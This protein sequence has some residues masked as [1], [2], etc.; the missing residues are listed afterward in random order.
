MSA[1]C[2]AWR[3]LIPLAAKF[4]PLAA[5]FDI[6]GGEVRYRWRRLAFAQQAQFRCARNRC[7]PPPVGP[8]NSA[9]P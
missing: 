6:A 4:L 5:K 8:N 7:Y 9:I 3:S 1:A 2:V